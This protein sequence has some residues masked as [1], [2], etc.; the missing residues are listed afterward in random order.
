MSQR[1]TSLCN[2]KKSRPGTNRA[3][4]GTINLK[5]A[6]SPFQQSHFPDQPG[7]NLAVVSMFGIIFNFL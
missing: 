4:K 3:G 5:Q 7:S 2:Q 6:L 1:R